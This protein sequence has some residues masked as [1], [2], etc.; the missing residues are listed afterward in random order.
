MKY[1]GDDKLTGFGNDTV[2]PYKEEIVRNPRVVVVG[3]TP[4]ELA[5]IKIILAEKKIDLV[6]MPDEADATVDADWIL[7]QGLPSPEEVMGK[8]EDFRYLESP[9]ETC[10]SYDDGKQHWRGGARGRKGKIKYRRN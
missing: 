5:Q 7:R 9:D 10:T 8:T 6:E 1:F 2:P 3:A 4:S